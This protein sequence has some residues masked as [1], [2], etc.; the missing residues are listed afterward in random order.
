MIPS[1][2][3]STPFTPRKVEWP[4]PARSWNPTGSLF[5]GRPALRRLV[6]IIDAELLAATGVSLS[7]EVALTALLGHPYVKLFRYRDHGPFPDTPLRPYGSGGT[8]AAAGWAVIK[9]KD[10]DGRP[11]VQ[12][13]D[14]DTATLTYM[15]GN[16]GE[17]AKGHVNSIS[18]ANLAPQAA[19][20]KREKDGLALQV[21]GAVKA[22]IF[23][24]ERPYLF[25]IASQFGVTVCRPAD[26]LALVCPVSTSPRRVHY[27]ATA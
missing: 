4:E 20:D 12:V 11:S 10:T 13:A 3:R 18:Y 2:T 5:Q 27:L 17:Y 21:A 1:L 22:D 16:A 7:R 19:A 14:E 6:V 8:E 23:I 24:T 9:G 26:A 25:G 15:P